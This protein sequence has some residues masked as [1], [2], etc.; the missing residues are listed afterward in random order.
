ML[1]E[2]AHVEPLRNHN[3]R[4]APSHLLR[5]PSIMLFAGGRVCCHC[6]VSRY[7]ADHITA[8]TSRGNGE[9][10]RAQERTG[11]RPSYRSS[12]QAWCHI[13][14]KI[15]D[16]QPYGLTC[17]AIW[18]WYVGH[19]CKR[20]ILWPRGLRI[21]LPCQLSKQLDSHWYIFSAMYMLQS[22]PKWQT[23]G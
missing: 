12:K 6:A 7:H 22:T 17:V 11:Y 13:G 20:D 5:P 14:T 3:S 18:R 9:A 2:E 21:S 8:A 23:V 19:C 15:P 1:A 4:H 10:E 16:H